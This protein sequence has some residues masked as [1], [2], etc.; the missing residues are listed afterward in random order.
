MKDGMNEAIFG[1]VGVIVGALLIGFVASSAAARRSRKGVQVAARLLLADISTAQTTYEQCLE[2]G[3]WGSLPSRPIPLE[4]WNQWKALLASNIS[5]GADWTKVFSVFVDAQQFDAL[6]AAHQEKDVIS[7][8]VSDAMS[9]ALARTD[10][11]LPVL[12]PYAHGDHLY[13]SRF[14]ARL[15]RLLRR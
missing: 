13:W 6:A 3:R 2:E 11:A 4:A 14:R 10:E 7:E 9:L 8:P 12:E 15:T 1:L 5:R